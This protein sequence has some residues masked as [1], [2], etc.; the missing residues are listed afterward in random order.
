MFMIKKH[1]HFDLIVAWAAG[2]EIQYFD[3][4]TWSWI[5]C[6]GS[7]VWNTNVQYQIKTNHKQDII[8]YR[9]IGYTNTLTDTI[10][11]NVKLVFDG[12][13]KELIE[14]ELLK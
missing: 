12:S 2:A 11:P 5:D 4:K 9:Y 7:P 14:I 3:E 6:V 10:D 8:T 1:K 13:T